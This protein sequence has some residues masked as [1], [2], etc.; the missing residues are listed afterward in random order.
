MIP[1]Y[2]LIPALEGS[3]VMVLPVAAFLDRYRP[4]QAP[5]GAVGVIVDAEERPAPSSGTE[6]SIRARFG[7]FVT[8]WVEA[9]HLDVPF[10]F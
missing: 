3:I 6:S 5:S 10:G 9:W 4:R 7:D 8:P 2:K 1:G